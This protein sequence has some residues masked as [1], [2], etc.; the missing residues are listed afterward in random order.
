MFNSLLADFS[1]AI[2]SVINR[3]SMKIGRSACAF[4]LLIPIEGRESDADTF[5]VLLT[6]ETDKHDN[7]GCRTMFV[8][9]GERDH[10]SINI[11]QSK[12]RVYF[13]ALEN[14]GESN[15]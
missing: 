13:M 14:F 2:D 1:P 12:E 10:W 8:S 9:D 6:V 3:F 7:G 11:I 4:L 15:R 5:A